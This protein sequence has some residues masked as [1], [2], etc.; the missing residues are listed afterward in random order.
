MA[1]AILLANF[2]DDHS[3]SVDLQY[4]SQVSD[5]RYPISGLMY[6]M[7]DLRSPISGLRSPVSR[8]KCQISNIHYQISDL[9]HK[10]SYI[11]YQISYIKSPISD[12]R[13]QM[14]DVKHHI[15]VNMRYQISD[16]TRYLIP[17]IQCSISNK[18]WVQHLRSQIPPEIPYDVTILSVRSHVRRCKIIYDPWFPDADIPT[19]I[20]HSSWLL[21]L[22]HC[23]K[24]KLC[25]RS[26][27][28]ENLVD[29]WTS[30]CRRMPRQV[31]HSRSKQLWIIN[32][33]KQ[34]IHIYILC[35]R[36][37]L[38]GSNNCC[39]A[40]STWTEVLALFTLPLWYFSQVREEEI[41]HSTAHE[42]TAWALE[43]GIFATSTKMAE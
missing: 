22:P 2:S 5:L 38:L 34:C 10:V 15:Y 28:I 8:I 42:L 33:T 23:G 32:G 16:D 36:K 40:V 35:V 27:K 1:S 41:T 37:N 39:D 24:P 25:L 30:F 9:H 19:L 3:S 7:S 6:Q 18:C 12:L 17:D 26:G 13:S 21:C 14:S 43:I 20:Q 31:S 4:R 29:C 11:Q